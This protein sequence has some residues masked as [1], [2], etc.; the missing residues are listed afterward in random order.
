MACYLTRKRRKII[1]SF[2]FLLREVAVA[3]KLLNKVR[4]D[5]KQLISMA[6]GE[7]KS[8]NELRDIAKNVFN[9]SVPKVWQIYSTLELN[10]TEWI[11][12]FKN[13]ITQLNKIT[14]ASDYGRSGLCDRRCS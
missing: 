8:T 5:L 12:D 1:K 2:G 6:K 13:R 4:D 14:Q 11:L 10:V 7:G 9:D 3:S